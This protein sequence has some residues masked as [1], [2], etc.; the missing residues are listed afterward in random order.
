MRICQRNR[1]RNH[2]I[3][4]SQARYLDCFFN[5]QLPWLPVSIQ[6]SVIINTVGDIGT[7]LYFRQTNTRPNGM[8]RTGG[9]EKDSALFYRYFFHNLQK[10]V[11]PDTAGKFLLGD[12]V[13]KSI[14]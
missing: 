6:S 13:R 5:M 10:T 2:I 8:E 1:Y 4:R 3:G 9:A 11:I 14:V 12:F 7:L